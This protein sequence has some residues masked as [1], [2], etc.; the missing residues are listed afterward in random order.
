[1]AY[2]I[3]AINKMTEAEIEEAYQAVDMYDDRKSFRA[4]SKR[5]DEFNAIRIVKLQRF[6]ALVDIFYKDI[7]NGTYGIREGSEDDHC[8]MVLLG[9]QYGWHVPAEAL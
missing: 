6:E 1:M 7:E 9:Q 8:E 3:K 2:T 4:I 5:R